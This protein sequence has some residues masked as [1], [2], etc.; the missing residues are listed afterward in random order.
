MRRNSEPADDYSEDEETK[1]QILIW[2][3]GYQEHY[4]C[5]PNGIELDVL[6]LL[7]DSMAEVW[8]NRPVLYNEVQQFC[9]VDD[10]TLE[11]RFRKSIKSIRTG[12]EYPRL[13]KVRKELWPGKAIGTPTPKTKGEKYGVRKLP[14]TGKT[15]R[16]GLR[17]I[18]RNHQTIGS[19][20][21]NQKA[22]IFQVKDF[23]RAI[24]RNHLLIGRTSQ[25]RK[26]KI[27]PKKRE[28]NGTMS[29]PSSYLYQKTWRNVVVYHMLT[30]G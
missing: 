11:Q 3:K 25:N 15:N 2:E 22:K 7:E 20:S 5:T 23:L 21:R 12:K 9:E 29:R 26:A 27:F 14:R 18:G 16:K 19:T 17:V 8:R 4:K 1:R 13:R 28:R 30:L 24:R 6:Y 10:D